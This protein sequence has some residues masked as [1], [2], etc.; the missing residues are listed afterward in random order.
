MKIYLAHN[1]AARAYLVDVIVELTNLGHQITST[2]ITNDSH[3]HSMNA[4]QSAEQDLMDIER[5]DAILLFT[6]QFSDRPGK[7][8]FVEFGYAI[9]RNKRLFIIGEDHNCIFYNLFKV[10]HIKDFKELSNWATR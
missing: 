5:S 6:D 2:W 3:L 4:Q 1:F 8:K 10:N 9:A 7:G